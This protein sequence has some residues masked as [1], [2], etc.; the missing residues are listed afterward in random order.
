[1]LAKAHEKFVV[2]D[3]E[4]LPFD[5]PELDPEIVN[6]LSEDQRYLYQ[7][8]LFSENILY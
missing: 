6:D 7:I 8:Y 4:I 1:M 3:F 5:L 2:V